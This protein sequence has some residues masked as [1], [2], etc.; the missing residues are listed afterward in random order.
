[1]KKTF[2]IKFDFPLEHS[3]QTISVKAVASLHHSNPYYVIENFQF[4]GKKGSRQH[5]SLLPKQEIKKVPKK[6]NGY[7]WVDRDSGKESLLS[8]AIGK[9]IDAK[10]NAEADER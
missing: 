3:E 5:M 9:A 8:L 2:E 10:G 7:T 1:M 6:G 4:A